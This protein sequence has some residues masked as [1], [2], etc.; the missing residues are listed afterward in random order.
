[1]SAICFDDT[2]PMTAYKRQNTLAMY[3]FLIFI[4]LEWD[5]T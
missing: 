2:Y 4:S 3:L 1:M 5:V